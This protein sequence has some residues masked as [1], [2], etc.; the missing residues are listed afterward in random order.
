MFHIYIYKELLEF[1]N[2]KTKNSIKIGKIYREKIYQR[3]Y[4]NDEDAY[5]K[6]LNIMWH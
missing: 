5:E 4:R 6:I 2:R 3:V 1:N